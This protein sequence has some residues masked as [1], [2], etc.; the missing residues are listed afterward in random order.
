MLATAYAQYTKDINKAN[1]FDIMLGYEY[2]H[3]KYWG[4]S[5]DKTFYPS[6]YEGKSDQ[7]EALAGTLKSGNTKIG[8]VRYISSAGMD[9]QTTHCW[10]V[11]SLHSQLVM[12]VLADLPMVIVGVSSH[13]LPL[14]GELRMR[15]S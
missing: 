5:W 4:N 15:N 12:M 7:G 6:T 10:I 11:I 13:Q 9:V 8:K 1:H 14:L 2:N 3:M